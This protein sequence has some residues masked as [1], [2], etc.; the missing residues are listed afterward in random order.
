MKVRKGETFEFWMKRGNEYDSHNPQSKS[1]VET[2]FGFL[3]Y[4]S[5]SWKESIQNLEAFFS[6][7]VKV[8]FVYHLSSV[9]ATVPG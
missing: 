2:V 4:K 5:I 1:S 8:S 9:C 3:N 7:F 6:Y